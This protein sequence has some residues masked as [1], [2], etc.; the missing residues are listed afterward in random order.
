MKGF[1]NYSSADAVNGLTF[2]FHSD[3]HII[4]VWLS[5]MTGKELVY[6]DEKL[7]LKKR[8]VFKLKTLDSFMEGS[9]HYELELHTK[10]Y[11]GYEVQ[12]YVFRNGVI[13]G[14]QICRVDNL[15]K[16]NIEE[17]VDLQEA[18]ERHLDRNRS[19]GHKALH[20]Y[21]LEEAQKSYQ[22]VLDVVPDDSESFLFMACIASLEERSDAGFTF[23]REALAAGLSGRDRILKLDFLAFLRM[24][25]EFDSFRAEWKL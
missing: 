20:E 10:L 19:R 8:N 12:V 7:V 13:L 25:S 16:Y 11:A 23:L 15:G 4:R 24:Q 22:A 5:T 18:Q 9:T 2:V 17:V 14:G 1:P 21:D 3:E 6:I